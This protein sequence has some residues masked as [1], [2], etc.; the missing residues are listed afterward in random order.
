MKTFIE[1][2]LQRQKAEWTT[3]ADPQEV[4]FRIDNRGQLF[5]LFP[6]IIH[7]KPRL[8]DNGNAIEGPEIGMMDAKTKKNSLVDISILVFSTPAKPEQYS[9]FLKELSID[10]KWTPIRNIE[11]SA[12]YHLLNP[13]Q[14]E[15]ERMRMQGEATSDYAGFG[16]MQTYRKGLFGE[17]I[18]QKAETK[19]DECAVSVGPANEFPPD[20]AHQQITKIYNRLNT[21]RHPII[22]D[23]A[24]DDDNKGIVV[25]LNKSY[26]NEQ[27]PTEHAQAIVSAFLRNTQP[28]I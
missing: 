14:A 22:T 20:I 27:N 13:N 23:I 15:R 12:Y 17:Y 19:G 18:I 8:V 16:D 4:M 10:G 25:Y 5:A 24:I 2:L 9:D 3:Y 28:I 1:F 6:G 21:V 26:L 11:D 7:G